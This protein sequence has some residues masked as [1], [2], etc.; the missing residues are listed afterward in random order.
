MG[1]GRNKERI[2]KVLIFTKSKPYS[3]FRKKSH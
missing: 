2:L 3:N 1:T